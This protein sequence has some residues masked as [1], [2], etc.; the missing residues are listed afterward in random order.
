ML[1]RVPMAGIGSVGSLVVLPGFDIA[2]MG[3][4]KYAA[5][6]FQPGI[7]SHLFGGEIVLGLFV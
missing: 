7:G 6:Q 3:E 5:L 2:A 4:R 1:I